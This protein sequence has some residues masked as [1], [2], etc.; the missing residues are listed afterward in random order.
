MLTMLNAQLTG[1]PV[2]QYSNAKQLKVLLPKIQEREGGNSALHVL[3][4]LKLPRMMQKRFACVAIEAVKN[5][6]THI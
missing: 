2:L 1:G 5:N 4:P 3:A 6:D